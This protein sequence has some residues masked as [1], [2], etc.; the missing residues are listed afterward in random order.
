M[1]NPSVVASSQGIEHFRYMT[2]LRYT[3][4]GGATTETVTIGD[5]TLS[6]QDFIIVKIDPNVNSTPT[7][8]I[9]RKASRST[10]NGTISLGSADGTTNIPAGLSL[11]IIII[12]RQLND[13][14]VAGDASGFGNPSDSLL[15]GLIATN[16]YST[17]NFASP[18]IVNSGCFLTSDSFVLVEQKTA[19]AGLTSGVT[20]SLTDRN[21]F[22][23]TPG[24]FHVDQANS[25]ETATGTGTVVDWAILNS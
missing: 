7:K 1:S 4:T 24:Q 8:I 15:G 21:N 22:G 11:Q 16:G 10:A 19:C 9:E 23:S 18:M 6:A 12:R 17:N 2:R 14:Q 20:E 3:T 13:G 25:G 5:I